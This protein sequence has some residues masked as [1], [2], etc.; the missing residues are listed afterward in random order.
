MEEKIGLDIE[1][2]PDIDISS[3]WLDIVRGFHLVVHQSIWRLWPVLF[4]LPG[5]FRGS[6]RCWGREQKLPG[7]LLQGDWLLRWLGGGRAR[8]LPYPLTRVEVR[9]GYDNG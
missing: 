3:V 9:A 4:I 7:S 6:I 5:S 8:R 1:H 2:V